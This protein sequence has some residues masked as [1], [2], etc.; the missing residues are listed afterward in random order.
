VGWAQL[1]NAQSGRARL[2]Q[3][4]PLDYRDLPNRTF[5]AICSI[6]A[7]EHFASSKLGSYF[8]SMAGHLRPGA[9]PLHRAAVQ[10]RATSTGTLHRPTRR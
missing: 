6:G 1:A 4:I 9:Q 3:V 5:D 7:M 10:P 8:D 2:V